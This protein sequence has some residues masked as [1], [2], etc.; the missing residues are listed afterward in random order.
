MIW[1]RR[2]FTLPLIL[3]FFVLLVAAVTVTAVNNTAANPE[4]YNDQMVKADMYNYVY[5]SVLPA[6]LE[7]IDTGEGSDAPIDIAKFEDE[8]LAAAEQVLPPW[9][10]QEQFEASTR[11][12]VPYFVDD[13]A[14]FS[15]TLVVKDRVEDAGEAIKE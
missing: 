3:I 14:G 6:V 9:W 11:I 13:T 4:F 5:D 7:E 1:L 10:L 8:I 2:S 12:L 15:Y